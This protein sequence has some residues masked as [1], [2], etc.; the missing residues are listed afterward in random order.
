MHKRIPLTLLAFAL[1]ACG[2][3]GEDTETDATSNGP[4]IPTVT[5]SSSETDATG[6][7]EDSETSD[8]TTEGPTTTDDP[9][10]GTMPCMSDDDCPVEGEFCVEGFCEF[11][12]NYCG[13][14]MVT[15]VPYTPP[16]IILIL[17]KSGSMVNPDNNW[18]DDQDD[19]DDD[20]FKDDD[21][22]MMATPK[23]T[24][25]RTLHEVVTLI[26][27][28][29]DDKI[30]MGANLF[31]SLQGQPVL[32]PQAC[33]VEANPEVSVAPMNAANVLAGIPPAGAMDLAGG[34]PAEK[35][36][37]TAYN[38]LKGLGGNNDPVAIL[39][40]DGAANCSTSAPD[41]M[42]LLDYD[43]NLVPTVAAAWN[44]DMIPTYVVGIDISSEPDMQGIVTRDVLN[45][46]ANAGGVPKE[47]DPNEQFYNATNKQ[48]LADALELIVGNTID[49]TIEL[50]DGIPDNTEPSVDVNG[51]TWPQLDAG[52]DCA[53]ED[54][55]ILDEDADPVTITLCGAACLGFQES[56]NL[57]LSFACT[58]VG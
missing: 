48:E 4:G 7:T 53:N 20:G 49:C 43:E 29:F 27:T 50:Q 26:G 58:D 18:D 5:G 55:W 24:R 17:D 16:N 2:G 37:T 51:M 32:G 28:E 13:E 54:G 33:P 21:P 45:D 56:G 40:T 31:P 34:T 6:E 42:A 1:T 52:A 11:D 8:E 47:G 38:H 36:V 22:M 9:S 3:G 19:L 57:D 14:A 23:V 15:E 10:A 44:N 41:D 30:N 25:W 35:G 39:I 12:P 46:V